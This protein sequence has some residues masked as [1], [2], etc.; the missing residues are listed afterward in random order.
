MAHHDLSEELYAN[1]ENWAAHPDFTE[2]ERIALEYTEKFAID[3]LALDAGFFE[4]MRAHW[5]DDEI[6]E[7]S[8]CVGTWMSLGRVV[9]VL[10]AEVACPLPIAVNEPSAG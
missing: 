3:H 7:I 1:V 9:R 2:A 8:I 6:V 10:G 4:R 5:T